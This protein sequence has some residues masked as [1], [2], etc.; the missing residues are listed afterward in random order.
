MP[1]K[2][3]TLRELS[4]YLRVSEEK[5]TSLVDEKVVPAYRIGGELLRFRK[6][7]IDAM[8]REIDTRIKDPGKTKDPRDAAK[9]GLRPAVERGNTF[10]DTAMDFFYFNDFYILSAAI[11]GILLAVIFMG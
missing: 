3:M 6:E 7:Q 2:L 10:L 11:A 9:P 8:R 5:L 1:E 4:E